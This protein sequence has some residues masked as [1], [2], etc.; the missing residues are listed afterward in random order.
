MATK[1]FI[2]G[3]EAV[4]QSNASFEYVSENPLFTE[5]EDYT[6]EM[7]FPL[8]DCPRN[9]SIFGPLHVK[10]V[11]ISKVSYPCEIRTDAFS[12]VGIL[13]ITAV[14]EVEV[15]GQF[16]EGMSSS[17][18]SDDGM[19]AYIDELDYSAYDGTTGDGMEIYYDIMREG[20]SPLVVWDSRLDEFFGQTKGIKDNYVMHVHLWKLM[21]II[22]EIC[23]LSLDKSKLESIPFFE[24]VVIANSTLNWRNCDDYYGEDTGYPDYDGR[25]EFM[26]LEKT[27]PHW[28]VRQFFEEVGKYFGCF[29]EDVEGAVSFRPFSSYMDVTHR[30]TI[31]VNDDFE[32]EV[33]SEDGSDFASLIRYKLPDNCNPDNLNMCPQVDE[34]MSEIRKSSY[35]SEDGKTPEYVANHG[36]NDSNFYGIYYPQ[37][38]LVKVGTQFVSVTDV[39][40]MEGEAFHFIKFEKLNQYGNLLDGNELGIV[41]CTLEFKT[42]AKQYFPRSGAVLDCTLINSAS[43]RWIADRN[44]TRRYW[45]KVPVIDVQYKESFSDGNSE[46]IDADVL[47]KDGYDAI[48]SHYDKLYVVIYNG[49]ES[50]GMGINTRKY[51]PELGTVYPSEYMSSLGADDDVVQYY[52]GLKE[53]GNTLAPSDSS[54]SSYVSLPPLDESILYRFKFLGITIPSPTSIFLI[55]GQRFACRRIT[56]HFTVDGMS[57]LLEGEFYRIID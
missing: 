53:Y 6:F 38:S 39:Q 10:G 3:Q 4:L 41:P 57:E 11:D 54:V 42:K 23:H 45:H 12:K 43:G 9:I 52:K 17:K 55:N 13:T 22:A 29:V 28:S 36:I 1:I 20:W 18:F 48:E 32:I 47:R 50:H 25:K 33:G 51:E 49:G 31:Q 7:P 34:Y 44:A 15:K 26:H 40:K 5:A 14:S 30:E 37:K 19:N 46:Y 2:N 21:D 24:K 35:A 56:A 16:L 27:L 8:K